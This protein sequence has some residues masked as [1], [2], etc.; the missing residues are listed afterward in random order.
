LT[1]LGKA[2]TGQAGSDDFATLLPFPRKREP[3]NPDLGSSPP[4]F[5]GSGFVHQ[6]AP[7]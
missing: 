5:M 1:T 4:L 3:V 6:A 2:G 7:E